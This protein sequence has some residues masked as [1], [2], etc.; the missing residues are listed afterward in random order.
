MLVTIRTPSTFTTDPKD[1]RSETENDLSLRLESSLLGCLV[2]GSCCPLI[3]DEL[4]DIDR[5]PGERHRDEGLVVGCGR[6]WE[7]G[8]IEDIHILGGLYMSGIRI[9]EPRRVER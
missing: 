2:W 8:K 3:E 5:D 7:R 6:G 9:S 1:H 4:T